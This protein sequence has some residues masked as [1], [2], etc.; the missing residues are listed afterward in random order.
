M[1]NIGAET[2][3]LE[4]K[5]STGEMKEAIIS[6]ASI[7]NKHG[8][9]ELYFGVKNNGDVLGQDVSDTTLRDV[10]KAVKEHIVPAINP[11]IVMKTFSNG[12]KT[13]CVRFSGDQTYTG[14]IFRW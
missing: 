9:G 1:E 6:I 11:E 10:S 12:V 5:K 4:F 14:R 3:M 8:H 7:L 2:E 13:V